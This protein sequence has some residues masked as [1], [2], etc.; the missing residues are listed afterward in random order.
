MSTVEWESIATAPNRYQ[1]F[2]DAATTNSSA[3]VMVTPRKYNAIY[4]SCWVHEK[5][6]MPTD[7]DGKCRKCGCQHAA[8][9][10]GRRLYG[11]APMGAILAAGLKPSPS[12]GIIETEDGDKSAVVFVDRGPVTLEEQYVGDIDEDDEHNYGD[13]DEDEEDEDDA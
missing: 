12:Y 13:D 3:E 5:K 6:I 8:S 7:E 10:D 1:V 2:W 9:T 4:C 11:R